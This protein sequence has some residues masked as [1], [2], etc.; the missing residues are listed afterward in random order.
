MGNGPG[1][2]SI[3]SVPAKQVSRSFTM[4]GWAW[5]CRREVR[6]NIPLASKNTT[7]ETERSEEDRP[8]MTRMNTDKRQ[9]RGKSRTTDKEQVGAAWRSCSLGLLPFYPCVFVSSVVPLLCFASSPPWLLLVLAGG[10]PSF[11]RTAVNALP[12]PPPRNSPATISGFW[13]RRTRCPCARTGVCTVNPPGI[14]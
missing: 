3:P 14:H 8:R 11:P 9:R 6:Y 1:G 12:C 5:E 4:A 2:E 13:T 10:I 7:E